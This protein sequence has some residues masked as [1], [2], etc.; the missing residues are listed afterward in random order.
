MKQGKQK[1]LVTL[2]KIL[3]W[4][5]TGI[6]IIWV[7]PE[8]IRNVGWN[9]SYLPFLISV[10][11]ALDYSF[12]GIIDGWWQRKVSTLIVLLG[13]YLQMLRVS[14]WFELGLVIGWLVYLT[15]EG[16]IRI[17]KV[18]SHEDIKTKS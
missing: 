3:V 4:I 18:R 7:D 8:L 12:K 5:P 15:K 6:I 16:S 11:I 17:L 9:D 14:N 2:S 13:L 10:G 1:W